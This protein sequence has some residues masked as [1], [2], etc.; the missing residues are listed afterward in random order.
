MKNLKLNKILWLCIAVLSLIIGIAGVSFP[1]IY[2]KFISSDL[3]PEVFAGDIMIIV[4][5]AALLILA[6]KQNSQD[7]KR[8]IFILGLMGYLFY[9]TGLKTL[10]QLNN[11]LYLVYLAVFGLSLWSIVFLFSSV[12]KSV[13]N[14]VNLF[15]PVR[16]ISTVVAL[17]QPFIAFPI[18]ISTRMNLLSAKSTNVIVSAR[19]I[20]D[21]I[22]IMPLFIY[23]SYLMYSRRGEGT[24]Y[25]PAIFILGFIVF[26]GYTLSE[27]IKPLFHLNINFGFTIWYSV[28]AYVF[29]I[30]AYV[31]IRKFK[32]SGN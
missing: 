10:E 17:I 9:S 14:R 6:I 15:A 1:S 19:I 29:F 4:S 5:A 32:F 2:D 12:H 25:V 21:L 7:L 22:V 13:L 26:F 24:F 8:L 23:S 18:L 27:L 30:T 20:M 11:G 31:H 3:R 16:N 28:L